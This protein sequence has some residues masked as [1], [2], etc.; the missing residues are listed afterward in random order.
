VA[1]SS[2]APHS[3]VALVLV[4]LVIL[5]GPSPVIAQDSDATTTITRTDGQGANMRVS[6]STIAPTIVV[7]PDGARVTITSDAIQGSG[8]TWRQVR[9]ADGHVGYVVVD[10]L[11][12]QDGAAVIPT[13]TPT[14]AP[15]QQAQISLP[16]LVAPT[17]T[18]TP[19]PDIADAFPAWR[20]PEGAIH[21][22]ASQVIQEQGINPYLAN[23]YSRSQVAALKL[24]PDDAVA[25][26]MA[27][28][29]YYVG[30]GDGSQL[31]TLTQY[32]ARQASHRITLM[33]LMGP[34]YLGAVLTREQWAELQAW[35]EDTCLGYVL[36]SPENTRL[37]RLM[38][39]SVGDTAWLQRF[40]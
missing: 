15:A 33:S 31:M 19:C 26:W 4:V 35:P 7:V 40:Q 30:R 21:Q 13:S 3:L 38:S 17:P 24:P 28:F 32:V 2:K 34:D 39:K 11:A 37:V 8:R 22:A 9:D 29:L 18:P 6:P 10:F 36:R 23:P 27:H 5:S 20:D 25:G 1:W 14:T 12:G 16:P